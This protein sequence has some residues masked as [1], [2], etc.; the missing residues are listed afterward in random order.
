MGI[1]RS[2]PRS[3]VAAPPPPPI[4]GHPTLGCGPLPMLPFAGAECA[5]VGSSD[6]LRLF[7]MGDEIDRHPI[8]LRINQAPT[9]GFESFVGVHTTVRL[10][11]HVMS[12][13]W[14]GKL[15]PKAGEFIGNGSEYPRDLC[16]TNTSAMCITTD[17]PTHHTMFATLPQPCGEAASTGRVAVA[18]ALR[19]CNVVSVY[20]F[21]PDCCK[22][23]NTWLPGLNYKYYHTNLSNWVCC[24]GGR[25][26]MHAELSAYAVHPRVRVRHVTLRKYVGPRRRCVVVGAAHGV[27]RRGG[28]SR[29]DGA[30]VV[31]RV[32]HAPAGGVYSKLV[33]TKTSIRT[34]GDGTLRIMLSQ[35]H[36]PRRK[37]DLNVSG[38]C[39][40]PERCIFLSKYGDRKRYR[41]ASR[42]LLRKVNDKLGL[43]IAAAG[44]GF[45]RR[46]LLFKAQ[47]AVK[48][49]VKI[50][51]SGGLATALYAYEH[52]SRV[53]V[54]LMETRANES[55][56]LRNAPYAYYKA[57]D[58]CG[59]SR[60]TK[61]E[62]R[63]WRELE[64]LGVVVRPVQNA[65]F[66]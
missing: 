31:F 62:E 41:D 25:E 42:R 51:L 59:S 26:N 30:D 5:V 49:F 57:G 13:N 4:A 10:A 64:R 8:V 23:H 16:G 45:T 12:D 52:C 18:M 58:C 46:S 2:R 9:R 39:L 44:A 6:L 34:V 54:V 61:D 32:N 28:Q 53:E 19:V 63:A 37:N 47:T 56:C 55:C 22:P 15:K 29:I 60:E 48:R 36:E 33:G 17:H 11:N 1:G 20:G 66:S 65:Q 3:H 24:H 27:P 40:E 14:N 21:F 43:S 35:L 38:M 7:P 50:T